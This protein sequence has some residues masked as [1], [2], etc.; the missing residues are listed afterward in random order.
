MRMYTG[1]D[2]AENPDVNRNAEI[3][4]YK[5]EPTLQLRRDD[6]TFDCPLI[7]WKYNEQKYKLLSIL[8]AMLLC[9][10]ATS[11]PSEHV[12]LVG[13]SNNCQR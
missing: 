12:F 7:W 3:T 2:A 9:I 11:A 1:G 5:Q 10:P 6:G 8:A 13:R 4:L